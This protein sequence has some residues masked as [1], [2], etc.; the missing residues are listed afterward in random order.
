MKLASTTCASSTLLRTKFH[1]PSLPSDLID[2]PRLIDELNRG[3]DRP[4]SLVTAPAGYGKTILVSAW[5]NTC[6]AAQR[7][8]VVG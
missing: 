7:L 1:R 3:L 5:L 6:A 2:R 4:L 8:A